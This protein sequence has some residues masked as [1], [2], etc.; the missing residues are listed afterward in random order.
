MNWEAI[1]AAAE[2]FGVMA[3]L[4]SLIYVAVQIRQ[5]NVV[6][7]ADAERQVLQNWMHALDSLVVDSETTDA[8]L[9]GL[10]DFDGLTSV[11]KTRLSYKLIELNAVH[12]AIEL[13]GE[14]GLVDEELVKQTENVMFSYVLTPGGRRWWDLNGPFMPNFD[15]IEERLKKEGDTFPSFLESLPYH[16]IESRPTR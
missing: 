6:A 3:I 7:Q 11:E 12:H 10:A 9:R 4:I 2:V 13:M 1:G 15:A 8:F 14:K 16:V 5:S